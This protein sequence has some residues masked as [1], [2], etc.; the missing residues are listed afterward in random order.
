[1]LRTLC[2]HLGKILSFA[3]RLPRCQFMSSE[4]VLTLRTSHLGLGVRMR[5]FSSMADLLVS[6]K[7]IKGSFVKNISRRQFF[8]QLGLKDAAPEKL[9]VK[10]VAFVE[11]K[12]KNFSLEKHMAADASSIIIARTSMVKQ[13]S[14]A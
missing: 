2:G 4:A 10:D 11:L 7:R 1:M 14:V 13:K 12:K 5:G 6:S 9:Q 8:T 3:K